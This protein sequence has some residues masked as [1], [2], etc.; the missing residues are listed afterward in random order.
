MDKQVIKR[1]LKNGGFS[2]S[3]GLA[4]FISSLAFWKP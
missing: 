3:I 4:T 2:A 1:V